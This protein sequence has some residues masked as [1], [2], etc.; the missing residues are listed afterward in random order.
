MANEAEDG[1]TKRLRDALALARKI[2][3]DISC[4]THEAF[5]MTDG[6]FD[7]NTRVSHDALRVL[8][9][10]QNALSHAIDIIPVWLRGHGP[11]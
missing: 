1:N 10:A 4:L 11:E 3:E 7:Y 5:V 6:E 2:E 8:S 9:Q